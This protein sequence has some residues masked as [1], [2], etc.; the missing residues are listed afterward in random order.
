MRKIQ[1]TQIIAYIEADRQSRLEN[2][3]FKANSYS[4]SEKYIN[5]LRSVID[6]KLTTI[7]EKQ[8]FDKKFPIAKDVSIIL[9]STGNIELHWHEEIEYFNKPNYVVHEMS[10]NYSYETFGSEDESEVIEFV[11]EEVNNIMCEMRLSGELDNLTDEEIEDEETNQYSYFA[12]S[13][14]YNGYLN[15]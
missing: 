12:I 1:L 4:L 11:T 2:G 14:I 10:G 15:A 5:T 13:N 3:T 6:D 7:A 8:L 9:Y